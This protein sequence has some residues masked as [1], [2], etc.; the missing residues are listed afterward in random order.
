M[1]RRRRLRYIYI[2]IYIYI[3][4]YTYIYIQVYIYIYI[5]IYMYL[6]ID[7]CIIYTYFEGEC[8][9]TI[10]LAPGP[11]QGGLGAASQVTLRTHPR[12]LGDTGNPRK[13]SARPLFL[14]M[15]AYLKAICSEL[16]VHFKPTTTK[17]PSA[18]KRDLQ[19]I[20]ASQSGPR[21]VQRHPKRIQSRT[22]E[23]KRRS[24]GTQRRP[25][26]RQTIYT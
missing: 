14:Q 5:Y 20:K 24:K 4:I 23:R 17:H 18:D 22:K 15:A 25:T 7:I 2:Y 12:D 26:S 8:L 9:T 3:N 10:I 6:Y 19:G 13:S 16:D 11:S 1:Q 21:A